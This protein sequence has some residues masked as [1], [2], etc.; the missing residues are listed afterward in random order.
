MPEATHKKVKIE[1][2]VEV[3]HKEPRVRVFIHANLQPAQYNQV[4]IGVE[5]EE[6]VKVG[7]TPGKA[8]KRVS[9]VVLRDL[10]AT[11]KAAFKKLGFT[12]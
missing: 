4:T 6:D 1:Q 8:M 7:E 11:A 3:H 5:Y 9:A 10:D 12:L 2:G